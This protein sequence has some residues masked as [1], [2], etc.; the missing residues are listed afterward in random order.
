MADPEIYFI[1]VIYIYNFQKQRKNGV[2]GELIP[3]IW[4]VKKYIT[5]ISVIDYFKYSLHNFIYLPILKVL[6]D[7]L[8]F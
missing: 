8:Q 6:C 2:N 5:T 7:L 3:E 4:D 1:R